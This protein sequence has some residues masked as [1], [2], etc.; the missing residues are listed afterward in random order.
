M[1]DASRIEY[2]VPTSGPASLTL[3][4]VSGREIRTLVNGPVTAGPHEVAWDGLDRQGRQVP[5]G[6][7]FYELNA[8]GQ[9][10]TRRLVRLR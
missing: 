9:H 4:D 7:Y 2:S 5:P 3:F 1:L 6:A 10:E 8:G